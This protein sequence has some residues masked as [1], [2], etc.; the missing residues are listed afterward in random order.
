[1]KIMTTDSI[2]HFHW[3]CP[4][5]QSN[6]NPWDSLHLLTFGV[7]NTT[8]LYALLYWLKIGF[9]F[10]YFFFLVAI[11]SNNHIRL[12]LVVSTFTSKTHWSKR[13]KANTILTKLQFLRKTGREILP[14]SF[15]V[16]H[17]PCS[18]LSCVLLTDIVCSFQARISRVQL[19]LL[20]GESDNHV[21]FL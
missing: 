5:T 19:D 18:C 21:F 17:F 14:E 12:Q 13:F 16:P 11:L 10:F 15:C 6:S 20:Q 7:L 1:M 3:N 8:K 4:Q 9:F 2:L